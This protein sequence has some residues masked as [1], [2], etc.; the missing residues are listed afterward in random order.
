MLLFTFGCSISCKEE[1]QIYAECPS[2][3]SSRLSRLRT[4]TMRALAGGDPEQTQNVMTNEVLAALGGCRC[5]PED[6]RRLQGRGESL[7]S[8]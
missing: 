1:A 7:F 8:S 3:H 5:P 4:D 6:W 2:W